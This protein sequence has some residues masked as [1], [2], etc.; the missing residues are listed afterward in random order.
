M[1]IRRSYIYVLLEESGRKSEF[2]FVSNISLLTHSY[3]DQHQKSSSTGPKNQPNSDCLT[4]ISRPSM[5][6][7]TLLRVT[8]SEKLSEVLEDLEKPMNVEGEDDGIAE[9]MKIMELE[10]G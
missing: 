7:A 5:A 6:L 4:Y 8:A 3:R 1:S 2:T 9:Q 10:S